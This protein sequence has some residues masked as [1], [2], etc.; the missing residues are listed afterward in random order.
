LK[1]LRKHVFV[2]GK[3]GETIANITGRKDA[4]TLAQSP[5]RTAVIRNGYD[6]REVARMRLQ[7]AQKS[8]KSMPASDGNDARS[9]VAAM[10]IRE[11]IH[12]AGAGANKR[13]KQGTVE[14]IDTI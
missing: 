1:Q 10:I 3:R 5:R 11:H 7:A 12:N 14:L 6:S 13:L 4:Q 2:V 8:R 9:A